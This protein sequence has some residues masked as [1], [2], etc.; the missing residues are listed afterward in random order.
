MGG[1]AFRD[2][3]FDTY[4]HLIIAR[5]IKEEKYRVPKQLDGFLLPHRFS[6]PYL[7]HFLL[8]FLPAKLLDRFV[9]NYLN[10]FL[11]AIFAAT[12]FLISLSLTAD[13][14]TALALALLYIFTPLLF[15][16]QA[17]GPRTAHFTPRLFGEILVNLV[18][19]SEY[20]WALGY[21]W[22]YLILA[23]FL[24]SI[25]FMSSKFSVQ[26]LVFIS[27][28]LSVVTLQPIFV[29]VPVSGLLLSMVFFGKQP[30]AL[31]SSQIK[32]LYWYFQKNR[33]GEM[34]V[35]NRNSFSPLV[36]LFKTK[37]FKRL[38]SLLTTD[39]S[40]FLVLLKF[41]LFLFA[42]YLL[43]ADNMI[44]TLQGQIII[45]AFVIYILTNLKL[46]LFLGESERYLVNIVFFPLLLAATR[47]SF[48]VVAA[49]IIYGLLWMSMEIVYI[50]RR[51]VKDSSYNLLKYLN[52]IPGKKRIASFPVHLGG[53]RIVYETRHS[54]LFSG[55]NIDA[56][57]IPGTDTLF[58]RF[59]Y[60]NLDRLDEY[61]SDYGLNLIVMDKTYFDQEGRKWLDLQSRWRRPESGLEPDDVVLIQ[62]D[63]VEDSGAGKISHG[64]L[65]AGEL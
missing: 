51:Y 25:I 29:A 1:Q 22:Y 57:L 30:V 48:Q 14:K 34:H 44:A 52:S 17:I 59:P 54:W 41:P 64:R 4:Y 23:I 13:F 58:T 3:T 19:I 49:T 24:S 7:P 21:G 31:L 11:D 38:R 47:L 5:T 35:S 8:A 6:Y 42:L 36:Q 20:F 50:R 16:I 63:P 2:D 37:D 62:S 65:I 18:F 33:R 53:Y 39:N 61:V 56:S 40:Y 27:A 55:G 46:F 26:A 12:L 43:A 15:S 28:V 10:S 60:F 32:H 9:K 45:S